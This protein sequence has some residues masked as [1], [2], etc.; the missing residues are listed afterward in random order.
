MSRRLPCFSLCGQLVM[1]L[2]FVLLALLDPFGLSSS[3]DQ[4]SEQWL[5]RMFASRYENKGQHE[6]AVVLLDDAYL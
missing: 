5:N 1:G 4:A 3:S 6:I 2:I